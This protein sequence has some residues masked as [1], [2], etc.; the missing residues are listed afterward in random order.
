MYAQKRIVSVTLDIECYDDLYLEDLD[1]KDVLELEGDETVHVTIKQLADVYWV[2]LSELST[3]YWHHPSL[4]LYLAQV[5]TT[6]MND[7][8]TIDTDLWH[9][10]ME[11][12]G[13]IFDIPEMQDVMIDFQQALNSNED[14]WWTPKLI[15]PNLLNLLSLML[16]A[17]LTGWTIRLWK[18][19][20]LRDW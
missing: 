14:F 6:P 13:E 9:E 16:S 4:V 20:P 17:S 19:V 10:I 12:P 2:T 3:G 18:T 5:Q 8:D 11:T 7:F 1:W 15:S